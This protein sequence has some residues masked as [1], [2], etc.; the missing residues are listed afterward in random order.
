M[1]NYESIMMLHIN[2]RNYKRKMIMIKSIPNHRNQPHKLYGATSH[3][4]HS[5]P[6]KPSCPQ[7]CILFQSTLESAKPKMLINLPIHIINQYQ[8]TTVIEIAPDIIQ[9]AMLCRMIKS[10]GGFLN[11]FSCVTTNQKS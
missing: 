3:S 5:A 1:V 7:R 4:S 2:Q 11:Y 9:L 6:S 10:G 8:H